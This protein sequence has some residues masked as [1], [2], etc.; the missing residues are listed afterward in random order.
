MSPIFRSLLVIAMLL[1]VSFWYFKKQPQVNVAGGKGWDGVTYHEMYLH[2]KGVAS[3]EV[4]N[5]PFNKRIGLPWLASKL[6]LDATSAFRYINIAS[7][8]AAC[9]LLYLALRPRVRGVVAFVC[10]LP[11]AFYI[12]SPIRFP[13]FYPFTVDPP[14]M[15]LYSLAALLVCRKHFVWAGAALVVSA[16]FRESGIYMALALGTALA[17][18]EKARRSEAALICLIAAVGA[19]AA[20]MVQLPGTEYSQFRTV[21][22]SFKHKFLEPLEL[23]RVIACI[24]MTLAPFLICKLSSSNG[25]LEESHEGDA[26]GRWFLMLCL[27]M[28]VFG[29][30][31]TTRIF[32]IGY[33]LFALLIAGWIEHADGLTVALASTAGM[34]A[35]RFREMIPQPA[36]DWPNHDVVGL[37]AIT[38]DYAHMGVVTAFAAYWLAWWFVISGPGRPP[39]ESLLRLDT[40]TNVQKPR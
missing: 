10:L 28:A 38:P 8:F 39:L 15:M 16:F 6:P 9:L 21:M 20:A 12:Y 14:A 35:N 1:G 22:S 26:V 13:N 40:W 3:K 27:A 5:A 34:I 25:K 31:D 4:Y 32:F 29:G 23:L 36:A 11:M 33:P 2:Y 37:F 17:V 30:S 24:A 18:N 7:G 19:V